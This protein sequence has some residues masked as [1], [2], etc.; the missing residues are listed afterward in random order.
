MGISLV[1]VNTPKGLEAI[2]RT[3][4]YLDIERSSE[5]EALNSCRH[6]NNPPIEN[7]MRHDFM[8]KLKKYGYHKAIKKY[9]DD[10]FYIKSRNK[11]KEYLLW[12]RNLFMMK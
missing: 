12:V 10:N 9:T 11:V 5:E 2:E 3:N 1:V 8:E 7:P 6:L 4:D